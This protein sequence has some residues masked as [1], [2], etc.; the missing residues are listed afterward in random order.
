MIAFSIVMLT[1][2][3]CALKHQSLQRT[4]DP[5]VIFD[6][7]V[8][9][10]EKNY[11]DKNGQKIQLDTSKRPDI[12][13]LLAQS[14]SIRLIPAE[15]VQ[16]DQSVGAI[17][18]ILAKKDDAL[19][20]EGTL[21]KSPARNAGLRKGDAIIEVNGKSV[22]GL[23]LREVIQL[24]RGAPGTDITIKISTRLDGE[25]TLKLK[26]ST[27]TVFESTAG[28]LLK[29]DIGYLRIERFYQNTPGEVKLIL[30]QL[31][32]SHLKGLIIDVRNNEGG[33]LYAV[34]DV[35]EL[36]MK[37]NEIIASLGGRYDGRVH[38]LNA[39]IWFPFLDF[40]IVVMIDAKTAVGAEMFAASLRD[41]HH[42]R[43][44]GEK[45]AGKGEIQSVYPL[46]NDSFL[47]I[48]TAFILTPAGEPI[49][50]K[51]VKPDAE[52]ILSQEERDSV[53]DEM[54]SFIT[55]DYLDKT[56]DMQLKA[57]MALFTSQR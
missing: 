26:R 19:L 50:S 44:V 56:N 45:T 3:G 54:Q 11:I 38:E 49:H 57:A 16:Q 39:W 51:G 53:Y 18:L 55:L 40:P 33:V 2:A 17:G 23:E 22:L 10:I 32:K 31:T 48:R 30:K 28:R 37:R 20:I 47:S 46:R 24:L 41:N 7:A 52:V 13:S 42:A 5:A 9:L 35:A 27:S 12:R 6:Q 21:L 4:S 1:N 8:T 25:K 34:T 43:L 14:D 15:D 29:N 36:F